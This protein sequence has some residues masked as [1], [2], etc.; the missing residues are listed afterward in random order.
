[1]KYEPIIDVSRI[2]L[3]GILLAGWIVFWGTFTVRTVARLF[4][5]AR[6]R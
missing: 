3:S 5:P 4:A 6:S 2:A 1:M